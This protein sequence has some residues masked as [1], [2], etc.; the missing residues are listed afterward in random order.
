MPEPLIGALVWESVA[1]EGVMY[2]ALCCSPAKQSA[3]GYVHTSESI[4][5]NG[6]ESETACIEACSYLCSDGANKVA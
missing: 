1:Y 4:S 2:T 6:I 3:P 5:H